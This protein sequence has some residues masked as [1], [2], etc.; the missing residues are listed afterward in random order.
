MKENRNSLNKKK[1]EEI[2]EKIT[3]KDTENTE[4]KKED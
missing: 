4:I 2:K 1:K 3:T